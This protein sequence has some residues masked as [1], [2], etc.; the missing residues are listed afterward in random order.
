MVVAKNY[1]SNLRNWPNLNDGD[2]KGLQEFSDF[3]GMLS[4]SDESFEVDG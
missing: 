3:F 1:K 2:S 4:G